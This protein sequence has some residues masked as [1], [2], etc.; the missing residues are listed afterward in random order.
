MKSIGFIDFYLSEWHANN[1]PAWLSEVN[2]KNG[3]DFA[4]KYAWAEQEVSPRDGVTSAQWCEKFGVELCSSLEE[5][6]EKSDYLLILAPSDPEKHLQYAKTALKYGKPTYIDKTFAPNSAE[7]EEIAAL[8]KK[9]NTPMFST[10]A[11]RYGPELSEMKDV[12]NVITAGSGSSANE[13]LVHQLEMIVKLMGVDAKK[14]KAETQ[15]NQGIYRVDYGN[16]SMATAVY[17]PTLPF[18]V[19]I[20]TYD[21]KSVSKEISWGYFETLIEKILTFY[22]TGEVDFDISET[23]TVMK[24]RERLLANAGEWEDLQ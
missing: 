8:A 24:L 18:A 13:Y 10:S 12:K 15:G 2:E 9:Y 6:C 11:L 22:E 16:G 4:V 20:E 1:Y 17:A 14:I 19:C 21:G 7:A 5:L 3:T 23:L